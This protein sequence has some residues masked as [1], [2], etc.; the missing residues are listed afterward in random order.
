MDAGP[1]TDESGL[2]YAEER[3]ALP[4]HTGARALRAL[5]G[6]VALAQRCTAG[7]C[8]R[9]LPLCLG[10]APYANGCLH[11]CVMCG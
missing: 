8:W 7:R 3:S 11:I 2:V 5:R 1:G 4:P 6:S 10:T 9:W